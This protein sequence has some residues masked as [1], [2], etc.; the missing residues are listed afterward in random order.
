VWC[1]C[2]CRKQEGEWT[3]FAYRRGG[4]E[5]GEFYEEG[6]SGRDSEEA[7][8]KVGRMEKVLGELVCLYDEG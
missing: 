5:L 8:S 3:R 2:I 4:E 1:F 6:G 7:R